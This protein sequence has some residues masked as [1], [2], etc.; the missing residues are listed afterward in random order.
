LVSLATYS[1]LVTEK[2]IEKAGSTDLCFLYLSVVCHP[3]GQ[4]PFLSVSSQVKSSQTNLIKILIQPCFEQPNI[5][6]DE[7]IPQGKSFGEIPVV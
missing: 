1:V 7:L 2:V 4:H 5:L 3:G 6:L